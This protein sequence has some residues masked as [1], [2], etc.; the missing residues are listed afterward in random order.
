MGV[1][2]KK[3][4]YWCLKLIFDPF[5]GIKWTFWGDLGGTLQP[6]GNGPVYTC[7]C[8]TTFTSYN[9]LLN[10]YAYQC[11]FFLPYDDMTKI[12]ELPWLCWY[13]VLNQCICYSRAL[14]HLLMI[15]SHT[16]GSIKFSWDQSHLVLRISLVRKDK[17]ISFLV[18]LCNCFIC[19]AY[20]YI[21]KM[22]TLNPLFSIREQ[23]LSNVPALIS[24]H[25]NCQKISCFKEIFN[26]G[27]V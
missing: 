7:C 24:L 27:C 13:L 23:N 14:W 20:H 10:H 17:Y 21:F 16:N 25:L 6:P 5:C 12:T 22:T 11:F 9:F 4:T 15:H 18:F 8:W 19:P 2:P 3:W 26:R 1:W